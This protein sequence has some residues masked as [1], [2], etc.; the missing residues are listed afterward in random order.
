M[1]RLVAD[2]ISRSNQ[3]LTFS[4][5]AT[6]LR[7]RANAEQGDRNRRE[8]N[9]RLIAKTLEAAECSMPMVDERGE[10]HENR[11]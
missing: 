7:G 10:G 11:A 3:E 5:Y 9:A 4:V 8:K 2:Q 6:S 1:S